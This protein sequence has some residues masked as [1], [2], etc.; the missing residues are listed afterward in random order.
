MLCALLKLDRSK[1]RGYARSNRFY[2]MKK[3]TKR[4]SATVTKDRKKKNADTPSV[5]R[6]KPPAKIAPTDTIAT[7]I[8]SNKKSPLPTKSQIPRKRKNPEVIQ[9]V[10]NVPIPNEVTTAQ[11]ES[12]SPPANTE[13]DKKGNVSLILGFAGLLAWLILG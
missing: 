4:I 6:K 5:R 3:I 2:A 12:V 1:A 7:V 8:R 10:A 11:E 13:V 9:I